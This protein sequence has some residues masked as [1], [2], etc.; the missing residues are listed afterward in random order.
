MKI[1]QVFDFEHDA[2]QLA[3]RLRH[4]AR[5][6]AHMTIAHLAIQFGFGHQSGHRIDHQNVD[7]AGRHQS[8]RDFQRL[9]AVIG[10]RNQ[11]VVHIDA[12]FACA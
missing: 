7:G 10:L 4:Q 8:R 5:L 9:L 12:Q 2:G 6:Q 3:Q 1:R 11:Q